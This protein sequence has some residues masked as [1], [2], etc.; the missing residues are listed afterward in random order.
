M[1]EIPLLPFLLFLIFPTTLTASTGDDR[2]SSTF[3]PRDYILLDCGATGQHTDLDNRTWVGDTG[4]KYAPSLKSAG[5][6]A[7]SQDSSIPQYPYLTA[8]VFT[9]P[10]SYKFL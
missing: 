7:Q 2:R 5:S 10:F 4:S 1:T 8:R 3:T 9:T 6:S